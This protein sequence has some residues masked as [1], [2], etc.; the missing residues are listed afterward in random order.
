V[1]TGLGVLAVV[2]ACLVALRPRTAFPR[3]HLNSVVSSLAGPLIGLGVVLANGISL[4][5]ATVLLIVLL[6]AV[7]GPVLGAALGRLTAQQDG[8]VPEAADDEPEESR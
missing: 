4:T 7:T 1:V 3:L 2:L 5:S 8:A 6:L